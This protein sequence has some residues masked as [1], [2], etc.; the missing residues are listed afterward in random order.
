M[1][2]PVQNRELKPRLLSI[3]DIFLSPPMVPM[4]PE[5]PGKD[6][7][8]FV[9][10]SEQNIPKQ[11]FHIPVREDE[12]EAR[13]LRR[14]RRLEINRQSAMAFRQR[15]KEHEVEDVKKE[16]DLLSWGSRYMSE[17]NVCSPLTYQ[18]AHESQVAAWKVV[19]DSEAGVSQ[20]LESSKRISCVVDLVDDFNEDRYMMSLFRLLTECADTTE[21]HGS[22]ITEDRDTKQLSIQSKTPQFFT[23]RLPVLREKHRSL[24]SH[25][26]R[27]IQVT[28]DEAEAYL[29]FKCLVALSQEEYRSLNKISILIRQ[30]VGAAA[31]EDEDKY[32]YQYAATHWY[33]HL[34]AVKD[35]E[36]RLVQLAASFLDG[37]E[38]VSWSEFVYRL[39]G[40]RGTALEVE[41]KLKIWK[42]SLKGEIKNLLSL[43]SYFSGPYRAAAEEFN[44]NAGDKT[45]P[46]LTLYQ[47]G[48]Y[49]NLATRIQEA[50]QVKRTVAEGFVKLLGER[51][52]LA[53]K[54]ESAFALEYLG[55]GLFLEAESTFARLA[56]IQREVIG[57]DRPDYFQSLQ[58]QGMAELWMTKFVE[59][60]SNLTESLQG[61]L[62]TIGPQ[63]F[64]YLMSQL[65]L[66]QVLEYRG[67][68]R[69]ETLD[70]EHVWRDRKS[71]LGS[72]NP[73][74]VWARCAVASAYRK[75]RLYEQEYSQIIG[76]GTASSVYSCAEITDGFRSSAGQGYFPN[77]KG[78]GTKLRFEKPI[79][80]G[81]QGQPWMRGYGK[82]TSQWNDLHE[83]RSTPE[84]GRYSGFSWSR[85]RRI[86]DGNGKLATALIFMARFTGTVASSTESRPASP[87]SLLETT[88]L[89]ACLG[90]VFTAVVY[91]E[92]CKEV[93]TPLMIVM[94][95]AC[96]D[97][98]REI[99]FPERQLLLV[100]TF[101]A[102]LNIAWLK[103]KLADL[104][105]TGGL[106]AL[107]IATFGF[108]SACAAAYYLPAMGGRYADRFILAAVSTLFTTMIWSVVWVVC[109]HNLG[110][111]QRLEVGE[112]DEHIGA[113][114]KRIFET[115]INQLITHVC[116]SLIS[117][118]VGSNSLPTG[119]KQHAG[120]VES[121]PADGLSRRES[122]WTAV[123]APPTPPQ[124][125][126]G[127]MSPSTQ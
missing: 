12:D 114:T 33:R 122:F 68:G 43:G 70:Y 71:T 53:L 75:L 80:W 106:T 27:S 105:R 56:Q 22:K 126:R 54:A 52:P 78:I 21:D 97:L 86:L 74:A 62:S 117:R 40:S 96:L 34:I 72:D 123:D 84:E 28:T 81:E 112:Y 1:A 104:P 2:A 89:A 115:W 65:T 37:N 116:E 69:R 44:Q 100:A 124:S 91:L 90:V 127:D 19:T 47:L 49:F 14:Q 20:V 32:F 50:F 119:L 59:A 76:Y 38:F 79:P 26:D 73:M 103:A 82:D 29:A 3:R 18:S 46:F 77:I 58:R 121:V 4:E 61:L 98:G 30:N 94:P 31:A 85:L 55:Q 42:A 39:S 8:L 7:P 24:S 25:P 88:M 93:L 48:E 64:L 45:L 67:E 111:A 95:F 10:P 101:S 102:S 5:I 17:G 60:D 15:R 87:E 13:K 109:F 6:V 57:E 99:A 16:S 107:L 118:L 41:S 125:W 110:L 83:Y 63:S 36:A 120:D 108:L 113:F 35:P 92:R 23:G 9:V 66:G 51:N 11:N